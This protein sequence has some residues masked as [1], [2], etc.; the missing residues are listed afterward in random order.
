MNDFATWLNT[1]LAERHMSQSDLARATGLTRQAISNYLNDKVVAPDNESLRKI[2]RALQLP[3]ELVFEKAGVLPSKPADG[4][5]VRKLLH[6]VRDPL[7]TDEDREE[8][9]EQVKLKIR[10]AEKRGQ[11]RAPTASRKRNSTSG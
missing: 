8:I 7:L 1:Q 6:L 3:P 5:N 11:Y 10:I 9:L 4:E 2:A